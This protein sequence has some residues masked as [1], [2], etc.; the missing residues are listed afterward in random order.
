MTREVVFVM[1][2]CEIFYLCLFSASRVQSVNWIIQLLLIIAIMI[3]AINLFVIG[4]FESNLLNLFLLLYQ[5]LVIANMGCFQWQL[6]GYIGGG[7]RQ[8][9]FILTGSSLFFVKKKW[10]GLLSLVPE[11]FSGQTGL[12]Q[13]VRLFYEPNELYVIAVIYLIL[14]LIKDVEYLR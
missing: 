4:L 6:C 3:A 11:L 12:S 10:K 1:G 8:Y 7:Q 5:F 14:P 13:S 2:C 9:I